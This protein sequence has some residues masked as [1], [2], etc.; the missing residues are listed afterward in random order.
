MTKFHIRAWVDRETK[1]AFRAAATQQ[2]TS[3][4][5]LFQLLIG[6]FLKSNPPNSKLIATTET[7]DDKLSLRLSAKLKGELTYRAKAQ[8]MSPSAYW[9]ALARAHVSQEAF[10]TERELEVLRRSNTELTALGRNINQI[11]KALNTSLANSDMARAKEL[12]LV[13]ALVKD[14][15]D[16]VRGLIRAN[17]AAWGISIEIEQY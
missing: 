3:E 7:K 1:T 17:L 4:S 8:G 13:A 10:F 15:R 14:N 6:A 11:A 2:G 12:E 5:R 9:V 16:Y